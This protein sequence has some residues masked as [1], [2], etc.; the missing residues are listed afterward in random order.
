ML[1]IVFELV[2]SEL[3][4]VLFFQKLI[5]FF[6]YSQY[7]WDF[8]YLQYASFYF[9]RHIFAFHHTNFVF[10]IE[11]M[12]FFWVGIETIFNKGLN[13]ILCFDKLNDSLSSLFYSNDSPAES[14]RMF[15]IHWIFNRIEENSFAKKDQV[16]ELIDDTKSIYFLY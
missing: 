16:W 7:C 11:S 8:S 9:P 10:A 15:P 6:I 5:L 2:W 13:S 4:E 1:S 3:R 14:T 12:Q